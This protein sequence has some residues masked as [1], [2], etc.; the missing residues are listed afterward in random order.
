MPLIYNPRN[1]SVTVL[2]GG[3]YFEFK[4][5]QIKLIH[6][7]NI[8]RFIA[9][10][11]SEEGLVEVPDICGEDKNSPEAKAAISAAKQE[12]ITKRIS[13]LEKIKHNLLVS[14]ARDMERANMKGDPLREASS[15][16]KKALKE[17]ATYEQ[18]K[19]SQADLEYQEIKKIAE[20]LE[21]GKSK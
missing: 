17:L 13:F 6:N 20:S 19:Q 8:A 12:G 7:P 1:E 18:Q 9:L 15:G 16:E 4:P 10:N 14:L 5:E 11:K 2:A 3:N 21:S